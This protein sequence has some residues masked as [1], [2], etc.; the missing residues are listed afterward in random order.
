MALLA[1]ITPTSLVTH[2]IHF[3]APEL[4]AL[5]YVLSHVLESARLKCVSW[6]LDRL[7]RGGVVRK[8]LLQ[9]SLKIQW[10]D[11]PMNIQL[12]NGPARKKR[13]VIDLKTK[14]RQI[15]KSLNW[16]DR[17]KLN[18][19]LFYYIT[20]NTLLA[21]RWRRRLYRRYTEIL[22]FVILFSCGP[23]TFLPDV[24]TAAAFDNNYNYLK[25]NSTVRVKRV[26]GASI[27]CINY[28]K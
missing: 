22:L 5:R 9:V 10:F 23:V 16:S 26:F 13:K 11:K 3:T 6:R 12:W 1:S 24:A 2:L 25:S 21:E 4:S 20:D 7:K 27:Q 17:K 28:F 15:I 8:A 19:E 14:Y 18:T